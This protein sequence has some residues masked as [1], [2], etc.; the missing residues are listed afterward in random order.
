M[1]VLQAFG[2]QSRFGLRVDID[3][4]V[5]PNVIGD[6]W[7][8]PFKRNSFDAVIL[9]PPYFHL[10][11]TVKRDLLHSAAWVASKYVIW[12]HTIWIAGDRY[13]SYER[14]WLVRVGDTCAVRCLQ[15]FRVSD[16]K[17]PPARTFERG[18][19]MRYNR[20]LSSQIPLGI[21]GERMVR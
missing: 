5:R 8:L 10:N 6:A 16:N 21:V 11:Q 1:S 9:D 20:W 17:P 15:V 13:C 14:G 12:F 7:L 4:I 2:G 19:A 18:P 3:P